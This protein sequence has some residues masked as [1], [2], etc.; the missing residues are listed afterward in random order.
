METTN[1]EDSKGFISFK[2]Y[3]ESQDKIKTEL[4][5]TQENI[6]NELSKR[7]EKS[8][9]KQDKLEDKV[10]D[11][12]NEVEQVKDIVVPLSI[13]MNATADNTKEMSQTLKTF[14]EG[15]TITNNMFVEK[16]HS[17]DLKMVGLENITSGLASKKNYNLGV[18]AAM[19][20][21][22]GLFVTGLFQAAPVLIPLLF[23][24]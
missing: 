13:A 10:D 6:K 2:E 11:I 3:T 17:N 18:T 7:L 4:L 22:G 12:A 15:Q 23:N 19:I 24:N 1:L 8:E 5:R 21:F 16:F 20:T 9:A 14:A